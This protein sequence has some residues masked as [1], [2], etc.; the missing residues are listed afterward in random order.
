M[1]IEEC[2]IDNQITNDN[3]ENILDNKLSWASYGDG[4]CKT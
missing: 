4:S 3:M 1:E 2:T